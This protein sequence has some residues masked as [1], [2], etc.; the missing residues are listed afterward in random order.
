MEIKKTY[1]HHVILF[2][3]F[4]E[5]TKEMRDEITNRYTVLGEDAGGK[6]AGILFW[7]VKPNI[8]QRKNIHL[9]EV[10]IFRDNESFENFKNHPSHK[11]V[12]ELLKTSADWWVGDTIIDALPLFD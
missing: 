12:V 10:A 7:S 8:D 4:S 5:T 1:L 11:E 2:S 3:F 6:K 9:V